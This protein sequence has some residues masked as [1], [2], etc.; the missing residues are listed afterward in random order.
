MRRSHSR[1]SMVIIINI[2]IYDIFALGMMT[3]SAAWTS[4]CFNLT[5]CIYKFLSISRRRRNL[6]PLHVR[7]QARTEDVVADDAPALVRHMDLHI[8]YVFVECGRKHVLDGSTDFLLR[9]PSWRP[10]AT[11]N[12]PNDI[13]VGFPSGLRNTARPYEDVIARQTALFYPYEHNLD[14]IIIFMFPIARQPHWIILHFPANCSISLC[15]FP[16]RQF[17]YNYLVRTLG[18]FTFLVV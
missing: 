10:N 3:S 18:M 17:N 13:L 9:H 15:V 2:D 8:R 11:E 16:N 12:F 1:A 7:R 5:I 14:F 6:N 4:S